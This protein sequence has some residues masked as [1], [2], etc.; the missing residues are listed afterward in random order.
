MVFQKYKKKAVTFA[1]KRYIKKKSGNIKLSQVA[2][3]LY[4]IKRS[5]NVEHKHID[6]QFGSGQAVAAQLPTKT[7]PIILALPVPARGTG[8]SNR[9]GNQIKVTHLTSKLQFA[10][11]NN[12]DLIQRTSVSAKLLWA[13]S[14]DDVPDITKLYEQDA[15]GHYTPMSMANTQEWKKYKW[16]KGQSHF[17]GYTQPTNRFPAS[18]NAGNVNDP[19]YQGASNISVL[20][21]AP[22][23]LNYA[24][25]YS[26]K[27]SKTNTRIS[28]QNGSDTVVEQYKPYLLLRSDVV[29]AA[30]DHDPISVSGTI[31]M[32]YVDN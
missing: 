6:F 31:R 8:Y 3:D 21:P 23:S 7:V 14:G 29:D 10:F 26:N 19:G 16:E 24:Q 2:K 30:T 20:N 11:E 1:K 18:N 22:Q 27:M 5:L 15:N 12:S 17:K 13:K 9:I 28:F 25:F 32:T 4:T